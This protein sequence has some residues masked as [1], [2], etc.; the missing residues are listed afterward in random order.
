[1]RGVLWIL[2]LCATAVAAALFLSSNQATVTLFWHP[3]RVDMSLNLL[4]LLLLTVNGTLAL[5]VWA[6]TSVWRMPAEARAWRHQRQEI[7]AHRALV[8][9]LEHF[10]NGQWSQAIDACLQAQRL[11]Q[12]ALSEPAQAEEARDDKERTEMRQLLHMCQWLEQR[13]RSESHR[14]GSQGKY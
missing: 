8:D 14:S 5:L 13:A 11:A 2:L 7:A 1:M 10:S 4:L 6:L 9:A 3:Y 12:D